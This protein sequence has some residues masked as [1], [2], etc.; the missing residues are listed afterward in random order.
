MLIR[1][2]DFYNEYANCF[3][4]IG[5]LEHEY[6]IQLKSDAEPV[7]HAPRLVLIALREKFRH[8]LDRMKRLDTIEK[9]QSQNLLNG[10]I[11]WLLSRNQMAN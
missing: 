9:F 2:I 3:G 11:L 4:D 6:K 7:I 10:L 8:E 1:K 5:L